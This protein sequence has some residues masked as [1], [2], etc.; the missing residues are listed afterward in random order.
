[1][2]RQAGAWPQPTAGPRL[3]RGGH[4]RGDAG[5]P[6]DD[7]GAQRLPLQARRPP[8]SHR[9]PSQAGQGPDGLPADAAAAA[10][11]L[12]PGR[13]GHAARRDRA[14]ARR[15][16]PQG[17]R[18]VQVELLRGQQALLVRGRLAARPWRHRDAYLRV[19]RVQPHQGPLDHGHG[20]TGGGPRG[21]PRHRGRGGPPA[22][23]A[24]GLPLGDHATERG[25]VVRA[26][27]LLD[28]VARQQRRHWIH[29]LDARRRHVLRA[30][31]DPA[32]EPHD[33]LR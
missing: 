22:V 24:D 7:G 2:R 26:A 13:A 3:S 1:M 19:L 30:A 5:Q 18:V 12:V 28:R 27:H 32:R 29:A 10:H 31:R 21:D 20:V 14:A 25:D 23:G 6:Q 9:E 16:P 4:P 15:L 17:G 8:G 33:A 11:R